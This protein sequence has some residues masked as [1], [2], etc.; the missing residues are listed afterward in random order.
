MKNPVQLSL[1]QADGSPRQI[2]IEP[3]LEQGD[4]DS[5][6]NTGVYKI[7]KDAFGDESTL[8][9]EPLE[10]NDINDELPDK[11]NPDYLGKITIINSVEWQYD[12]DLLGNDEQLQ[13]LKCIKE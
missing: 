13:V 6:Q 3:V 10:I 2:I 4:D 7:Y 1:I 11:D 12:G 9:T 5:L 8:F